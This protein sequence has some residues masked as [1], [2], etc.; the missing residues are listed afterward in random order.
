VSAVCHDLAHQMVRDAEGASKD[1]AV[2][3]VGAA[4]VDD[5]LEVARAVGRSNLLK[6]ALHGN[7]PNWGR[8]LAAV[9]TT[10]AAFEPDDL[11]VAINDVQVC[12]AGAPGD[13]RELV[14]LS[15]RDVRIV[16][17]LHAGPHEATLWTSDLTAEYVHENSA[18]ST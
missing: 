4:S 7:D 11:D 6:C 1:I 17:D 10:A 14:D 16:V 3:V 13:A 5:A 9:G 2:E 15:G 18:Y 8:V 12:R